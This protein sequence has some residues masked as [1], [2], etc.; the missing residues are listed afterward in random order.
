MHYIKRPKTSFGNRGEMAQKFADIRWVLVWVL[1][2]NWAVAAAKIV[3]GMASHLSSMTADGFHSLA[4]G[5]S[6]IIGLVGISIAYRPVD[7]DHPYGHKKYETFFSLVI[8]ALLFLLVANLLRDGFE[9][10]HSS[11][12]PQVGIQN[13]AVMVITMCVNIFVMLYEYKRGKELKSD[14][15]VADS[16]H[17]KADIF[18]SLSVL[19]AMGA[20]KLGFPIVDPII[21]FVICGFIAMAAFE[22]VKQSSKV[23]CDSA[24]VDVKKITGVV[25]GIRSVKSCHKIRTRGRDDDVYMDLHVQIA[26]D[27]HIDEAHKISYEIEEAIKKAM[28]EVSDVLV[29]MEPA[30]EEAHTHHGK[31]HK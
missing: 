18:T 15:L 14:V 21:T 5:T 26:P 31:K 7:E 24:M 6:N 27:T 23:L 30:G 1:A 13:I 22:I 11:V 20:V 8:A 12:I 4:D 28:P 29:H 16:L 17:T 2:L 10:L 25:M 9:R 19:V 3:Y